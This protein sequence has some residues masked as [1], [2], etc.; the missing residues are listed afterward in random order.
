MEMKERK[1]FKATAMHTRRR[2]PN[3]PVNLHFFLEFH[4]HP[5]KFHPSHPCRPQKGAEIIIDIKSERKYYQYLE[6]KAGKEM[7][8]Y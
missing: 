8:I 1:K 6:W 4:L 7:H 2:P 5:S 3:Y